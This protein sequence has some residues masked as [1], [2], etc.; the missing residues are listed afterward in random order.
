M[1]TGFNM[2]IGMMLII[3]P[4][5]VCDAL[6][7]TLTLPHFLAYM[8]SLYKHIEIYLTV[9][10]FKFSKHVFGGEYFVCCFSLNM[11]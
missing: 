11:H 2:L 7:V 8:T 9:H 6:L 10:H 4:Y 1:C 3:L 5:N